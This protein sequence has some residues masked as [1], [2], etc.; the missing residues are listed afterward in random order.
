MPKRRSAAKKRSNKK[1]TQYRQRESL[2]RE[3]SKA[4]TW[5]EKAK[6]YRQMDAIR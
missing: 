6:L 5:E 4:Q 2:R 1:E 3:L